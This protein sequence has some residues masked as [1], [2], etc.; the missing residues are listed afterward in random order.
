[1]SSG[2]ELK[3]LGRDTRLPRD[4]SN[5]TTTP[6]R[7]GTKLVSIG[8][9]HSAK[10]N[11]QDFQRSGNRSRHPAMRG[12][13]AL[14]IE[15]VETPPADRKAALAARGEK[16]AAA[17]RQS[18]KA[19][20][21][22]ALYGWDA[23]PIATSRLAAE[24]WEAI[25]QED[26][27]IGAVASNNRPSWHRRLWDMT[28]H[29]HFTG[30]AAGGGE[31][32]GAPAAAGAALANKKHGRLT[33]TIQGDGDLMYSPGVLWTCAHS[34]LPILY[35]VHNNRGYHQEKM[36]IQ[37]MASRRQRGIDRSHIG[38]AIETVHRL[39]DGCQGSWR[40]LVRPDH[41]PQ[42]SRR[43]VEKGGC[44]V[45]RASRAGRR[46]F[47]GPLMEATMRM[48]SAFVTMLAAYM[49]CTACAYA[50]GP[51]PWGCGHGQRLY[52]AVG[53]YLCHG[54]VGQGGRPS[55]AHRA[56]PDPMRPSRNWCRPANAMPPYTTVV[57][58]E[59]DLGDIYAYLRTI[60]PP[61]DPKAAAI[62]DN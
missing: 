17:H 51:A 42:R 60:P 23:A 52:T 4:R 7:P 37:R 1:M 45:K 19:L 36:V 24:L 34:R 58:S 6:S 27:S 59:Q 5:A 11:Y 57:L 50:Q 28:K 56:E 43:R 49:N 8:A 40:G 32:Y 21:E 54:T 29:Y 38:C 61:P 15:A 31:G 48:Q 33:L 55:A 35:V 16:L 30:P 20:K 18:I 41:R 26:W 13:A 2:L 47:T 9:A 3:F 44:V 10:A 46:R 12:D 25:R 39:R 22:E 14:S 53:C 62:L